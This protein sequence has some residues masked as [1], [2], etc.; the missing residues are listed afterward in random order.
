VTKISLKELKTMLEIYYP[1]IDRFE[2]PAKGLFQAAPVGS[3]VCSVLP[4]EF[5]GGRCVVLR[6]WSSFEDDG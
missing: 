1:L 5:E 2:D 6:G 3:M 4:G